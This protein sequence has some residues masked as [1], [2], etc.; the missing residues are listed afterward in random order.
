MRVTKAN[1]LHRAELFGKYL[2]LPENIKPHLSC[3]RPGDGRRWQVELLDHD[4]KWRMV[5]GFPRNAHYR[6]R[7][8]DCYL[9]GLIDALEMA[10]KLKREGIIK[11]VKDGALC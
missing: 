10:D 1:L 8:F 4:N 11:C 6:T 5:E 7:D 2:G 3:F 9:D